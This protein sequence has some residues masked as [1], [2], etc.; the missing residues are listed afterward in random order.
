MVL[1]INNQM[2]FFNLLKKTE[3]S[4]IIILALIGLVL[5]GALYI[6]QTWTAAYDNASEQALIIARTTKTLL[7]DKAISNLEASPQDIENIQYKHIKASLME[8][9]RTEKNIRFVYIYT[10]KD[11]KLFFMV[12]SEPISSKDYSPPGQ[13][14]TEADQAYRQ[15]FISNNAL[16]TGPVSDRWGKWVSI[17]IPINDIESGKTIAVLGMDYDAKAW[18]RAIILPVIQAT[19]IVIALLLLLLFFYR[20]LVRNKLLSEER[21]KLFQANEEI[22]KRKRNFKNFFN[23]I[24]DLVFVLDIDGIIIHVNNTVMKRLGYPEEELVGQ[25]VLIIHEEKIRGKG[26]ANL[27]DILAGKPDFCMESIM[28]KGGQEIPVEIKVVVGDWNGEEVLFGVAKDISELKLSEQKFAKAFQSGAALMAVSRIEDGC[29]IDVNDAFLNTLGFNKE[30]VIGKRSTDLNIFV[31]KN[32]REVLEKIMES[33]GRVSQLEIPVRGRDGLLHT[34]IITID[35]IEIANTQCWL[36]CMVDISARKE[37]EEKIRYLSFHDSLTGVYNRAFYEEELKRLDTESSLPLSV[38]MGDLNGLKLLNDTFGHQIGDELLKLGSEIMRKVTRPEDIVARIGGDEFIILLPNTSEKVAKNIMKRIIEECDN[39]DIKGIKVSIS[40]G[41]ACKK[42]LE[43]DINIVI[44]S[45]EERMYTKKLL[46]GRSTRSHLIASFLGILNE[47]TCETKE[48]CY[49]LAE[50]SNQLGRKIGLSDDEL[51]RLKVLSVMHDIGKIAV[52][53]NIISKPGKLNKEEFEEI[54]KHPESGFRMVSM[55]PE[56]AHIAEEILSHH[57]RW[58]GTGYPRGLKK[59]EIPIIARVLSVVDAIDA[60]T[61]DRV[62]RKAMSLSEAKEELIRNAG[63]QFD[64]EIVRIF[65]E[66]D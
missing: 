56:F 55:T 62:Y 31:V 29:F 47:K 44:L 37:I 63:T 13:E 9:A 40:L 41:V 15:P 27:S 4:K 43:T 10:Q 7:Q 52:P 45:S 51:E 21:H 16:V 17:L 32:Q 3:S 46:E 48:H 42:D 6:R 5:L 34:G 1:G 18:S 23:T 54:S 11:E 65:I 33:E 25:S 66:G 26:L 19:F 22:E 60:M 30:E 20:L 35:I 53:D 61:N 38:I 28:T 64:P 2:S 49:R 58:D 12:D 36:T 24:D 39:R 8:L 50:L 59:E 14:Y 57:E